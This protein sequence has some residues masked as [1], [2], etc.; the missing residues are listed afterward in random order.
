[1]PKGGFKSITVS[2]HIYDRFSE[3]YHTNRD[4]LAQK[5]VR[6]L[7]G[8]VSYMLR[9]A[10][11]R[12]KVF[13]AHKPKLEILSLETGRAILKDN[14]INRIAEVVCKDDGLYCHICDTDNCIHIGAIFHSHTAYRTILSE[15]ED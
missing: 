1:M 12:D 9:E 13:A 10:M 5:G 14:E 11:E 4:M 7:S 6:S 3:V 15:E 8:Y 2:D